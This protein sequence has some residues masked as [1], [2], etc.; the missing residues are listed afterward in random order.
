MNRWLTVLSLTC[1]LVATSG[2]ERRDAEEPQ[3]YDPDL[4][5]SPGSMQVYMD[6]DIAIS[7]TALSREAEDAKATTP[8]TP[9]AITPE[10]TGATTKSADGKIGKAFDFLRKAVTAPPK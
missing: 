1:A 9:T 7:Q 4:D 6:P 3:G 5:G 2:C 8:T 10:P